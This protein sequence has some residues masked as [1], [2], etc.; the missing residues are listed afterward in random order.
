MSRDWLGY[1][2]GTADRF[3]HRRQEQIAEHAYR[4][5]G[6]ST[7]WLEGQWAPTIGPCLRFA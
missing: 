7:S 1:F 3:S 5:S 2:V 4:L 6:Y